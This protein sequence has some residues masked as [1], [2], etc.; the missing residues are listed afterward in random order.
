MSGFGGFGLRLGLGRRGGG[1]GVV[2]DYFANSILGLDTNDGTSAGAPFRTL[3][4]LGTAV[5][6]GERVKIEGQFLQRLDL[7]SKTGIRVAGVEP[8]M[9][10]NFGLLTGA[11]REDATTYPNVW[12][13]A[14]GETAV[15]AV[16]Y[17]GVYVTP[18][19]AP[20]FAATPN[21]VSYVAASWGGTA[22]VTTT[23]TT[24][25]VTGDDLQYGAI[26]FPVVTGRLYRLI[27]AF[28]AKTNNSQMRLRNGVIGAGSPFFQT[29]NNTS[30]STISQ[31]FV[32]ASPGTWNF[33][34]LLR[35]NGASAT[36]TL[37]IEEIQPTVAGLP[38][39]S[40]LRRVGTSAQNFENQ[41]IVET[42]K[43]ACLANVNS[44]AGRF[45][46]EY[47][48]GIHKYYVNSGT[49]PTSDTKAYYRK[50]EESVYLGNENGTIE[51]VALF[52]SAA[53]NGV[54]RD[55]SLIGRTF[56]NVLFRD[57]GIHTML[58]GGGKLFQ[59]CESVVNVDAGATTFHLN[60]PTSSHG[61]AYVRCRAFGSWAVGRTD[62]LGSIAYYNHTSPLEYVVLLDVE[63]DGQKDFASYDADVEAVHIAGARVNTKLGDLSTT[64]PA[65]PGTPQALPYGSYGAVTANWKSENGLYYLGGT[66]G[67][68]ANPGEVRFHNE[69]FVF[70]PG[71]NDAAA[72]GALGIFIRAASKLGVDMVFDH[73]T[74]VFD[75]YGADL[76]NA[77]N[78][79]VYSET[80]TSSGSI[81]FND[82]ILV[83][84]RPNAVSMLLTH[85]SF[86][87]TVGLDNC[88]ISPN[89][90]NLPGSGY[91]ESSDIFETAEGWRT[92]DF[93]LSATSPA[94]AAD[95]G[96]RADR[97]PLYRPTAV[98]LARALGASVS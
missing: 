86:A 65:L 96:W 18:A 41:L 79:Y 29:S 44:N 95:A 36:I 60:S 14:G 48:D 32:G 97:T 42:D 34:V 35:A 54:C 87:V 58:A 59:D 31:L 25:T 50:P 46:Y 19:L 5:A 37:T 6:S 20:D 89:F 4:A 8:T 27:A 1:A 2:F 88:T 11:T 73:C 23:T 22:T 69:R 71:R 85:G 45:Y 84:N 81:A 82:C 3:T 78:N 40:R 9:I 16:V 98:A 61:A 17:P 10:G 91:T 39:A 90:G 76:Q 56:K 57:G 7:T 15:A 12:L 38:V 49:T 62:I 13:F 28:T 33:E 47:S 53:R 24:I 55:N 83:V 63:A 74:I 93:A 80:G 21:L 51:N 92:G 52:G 66:H 43:A 70:R 72:P 30:L 64:W 94:I 77:T 75:T 67:I 68:T 26:E